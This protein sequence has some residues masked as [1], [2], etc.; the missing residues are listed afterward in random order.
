MTYMVIAYAT[1]GVSTPADWN[2]A[3]AIH[4]Y[5]GHPSAGCKH[6]SGCGNLFLLG[7]IMLVTSVSMCFVYRYP[8]RNGKQAVQELRHM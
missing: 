2:T 7:H 8:V 3:W 5:L 4:G 1:A 6:E